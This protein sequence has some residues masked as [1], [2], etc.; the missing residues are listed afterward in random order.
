M[1][2]YTILQG[3]LF[4]DIKEKYIEQARIE[5]AKNPNA[6][7]G[8]IEQG[9]QFFESKYTIILIFIQLFWFVIGGAIAALIGAAVT[10]KRPPFE[11]SFNQ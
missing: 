9:M 1:V 3:F 8:Q 2:G 5:A 7:P 10:K 4:P 6:D 11:N